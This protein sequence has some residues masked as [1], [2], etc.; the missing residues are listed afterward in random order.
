MRWWWGTI[1]DLGRLRSG[2]ALPTRDPRRGALLQYFKAHGWRTEGVGKIFHI[3]HGNRDDP[4]SWSVPFQ[5]D[6]VVEYV[7]PE[8]SAGGRLTREEAY[9]SNQQL[10]EI[11]RLPRGRA[12]ER[13][14]VERQG[15]CGWADRA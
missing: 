14:E 8:H 1:H 5:P 2:N 6:R 13:E 12:W 11:A 9:F 3:G 4:V 7:N 10:N 15:L